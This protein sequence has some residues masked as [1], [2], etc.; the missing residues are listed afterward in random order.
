MCCKSHHEPPEQPSK[1][2]EGIKHSNVDCCKTSGGTDESYCCGVSEDIRDCTSSVAT[3]DLEKNLVDSERVIIAVQGM[4]CTGCETKLHNFLHGLAPVQNVQT[5][6]VLS[7][8]EFGVHSSHM[9]TADIL[10]RIEN[11]T[12]FKC[13]QILKQW[14][15]LDVANLGTIDTLLRDK[16]LPQGIM[17]VVRLDTKTVRISYDPRVVGARDLLHKRF[18]G[19]LQLAPQRPDPST[20]ASVKHV[21]RL[22]F[23]T[24]LSMIMTIPVL[25]LAWA[26]LP[27]KPVAYGSVSLL[28]A[29]V[30][31]FVVAGPFYLGAF[32]SL[33]FS[34][35][36]EMDLLIVLSTTTAY[37]FSIVSFAY[38][39]QGKSFS[40]EEFFQTSTLLVTLIMVGRYVSAMARQKALQ[41]ISIG[42]LQPS[43]VRLVA[44]N[45]QEE[46]EID[47][48]LLQYGDIFKTLPDCKVAT[49]GRV[50]SGISEI[51]ESMI[52]GESRP[53]VKSE[54]STIIAS[55]INGSGTL[56]GLVTRLPGEN[57]IDIIA[58]M[59]DQA[60]LAKPKIQGLA[61][62]VISYF[63]L[64]ILALTVITF[65]AW[66]S[67]GIFIRI[68]RP[69]EAT[70][71]AVTY[72]IA[73]L[74]ISC[75]CAIGLAVPM[76]I[77]IAGGVAAEHG[78][79]FK[80]AETIENAWRTSHVV[81]DK[82]GTLTR[83][84]MSVGAEEH[85]SA[86][87]AYTRSLVLGVVSNVKHPISSAVAQHLKSLD[88]SPAHVEN[89]KTLPGK[90]V[91]ATFDGI[92]IRVGNSR[93]L[94][95][96][97]VPQVQSLLSLGFTVFCVLIDSRIAAVFGLN[98]TLRPDAKAVVSALLSRGI[99][100]SIV[101]GDD[102]GAVQ[103]VA[104]QLNIP[105]SNVRSHCLPIDKKNYVKDILDHNPDG[106]VLFCG[107]GT[108]DAIAIAQA[109]VGVHIHDGSD[110]SQNA[111][112]AVLVTSALTSV[113]TLMDL[114]RAAHVRILFNFTWTFIYNLFAILLAAGAI[115][116]ARIAPQYA[117]LGEIVSVLPVIFTA[118]QL[119]WVK[120]SGG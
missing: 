47:T 91:E 4:T 76:V 32:K 109:T 13:E 115:P 98:D 9:S 17:D 23:M 58:G 14:R 64:V 21:H 16:D 103:S 79:I 52:T 101:S 11:A 113:L 48:R 119:K 63:V 78:I 29:T 120:F 2:T 30:V 114:S 59:V 102:E 12:G 93:W 95:L 27:S 34:R 117:G 40:T 33:V 44:S 55:S 22:G 75:P 18:G 45:S 42:S 99:T 89:I 39:V 111:A 24:F 31:Q 19:L 38:L 67:V 54:G 57:T 118:L 90:G 6:L 35:V 41:S 97:A 26:P 56:T 94:D 50:I 60:R 43:V 65:A 1:L 68:E 72:A 86:S 104:V 80:S 92:P 85:F 46:M 105:T 10:H 49:D 74:I 96:G 112:D 87:Q 7:R 8:A 25:V 106:V 81:L 37:V 20:I 82:T 61:D 62:Q 83:G 51:D 84:E 116:R 28:L 77:A 36:A 3:S 15:T 110:V 73:V 108:N 69:S 66:T 71:Q 88:V 100:V 107:D 53:V 70:I 5:S